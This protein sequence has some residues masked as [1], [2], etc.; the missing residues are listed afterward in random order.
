M[1]Q[2][3]YT[4]VRVK[5][6]NRGINITCK[7]V[8]GLYWVEA[9]L[10]R[11]FFIVYLYMFFRWRPSYQE[12]RVR[13][14]LICLTPLHL[15]ACPKPGLKFPTSY[16]TRLWS[17]FMYINTDPNQLLLGRNFHKFSY[18]YIYYKSMLYFNRKCTL[19]EYIHNVVRL[20]V[21]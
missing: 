11:F 1:L 5:L 17:V 6:G 2:I 7:I 15:C 13:I 9:N 18:F 12:G 3:L 16:D 21:W 14:P 19:E 10:C 20:H 4:T 8:C